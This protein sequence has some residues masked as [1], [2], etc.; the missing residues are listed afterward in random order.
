MKRKRPSKGIIIIASIFIVGWIILL[1]GDVFIS[2]AEHSPL[3]FLH[4]KITIFMYPLCAAGLLALKE[5]GRQCTIWFQIAEMV[6]CA[7]GH[8]QMDF[9]KLISQ[10]LLSPNDPDYT[11]SIISII[12]GVILVII[13]A[14][15]IPAL[16]IFFLTRPK[17]KAQFIPVKDEVEPKGTVTEDRPQHQKPKKL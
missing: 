5:W 14:Y 8:F 7:I 9:K 1:L 12:L 4:T 15:G 2:K 16:I 10:H 6:I 3:E 17:V 13:F 11:F